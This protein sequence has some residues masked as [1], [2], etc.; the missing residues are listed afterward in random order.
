[1]QRVLEF[2]SVSLSYAQ[3]R[4]HPNK[5]ANEILDHVKTCLAVTDYTIDLCTETKGI[6]VGPSVLLKGASLTL[7]RISLHKTIFKPS[8]AVAL[9]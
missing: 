3:I 8:T 7:V 9:V 4:A 2:R 1:M 6:A 5:V